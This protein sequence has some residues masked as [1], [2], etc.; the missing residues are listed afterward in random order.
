[1]PINN[2]E[3]NV[4]EPPDCKLRSV[5]S[6][7]VQ[8]AANIKYIKL[9]LDRCGHGINLSWNRGPLCGFLLPG[10]FALQH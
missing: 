8:I 6:R 2:N 4:E 3:N 5:S 9:S 10:Q 7:A 1:M